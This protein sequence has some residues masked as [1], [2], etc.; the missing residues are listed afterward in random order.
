MILPRQLFKTADGAWCEEDDVRQAWAY[1]ATGMN[2]PDAEAEK[3]GLKAYL[4]A[5]DKAHAKEIKAAEKAE[6]KAVEQAEVEDKAV[7]GPMEVKAEEQTTGETEDK[8]EDEPGPGLHIPLE[9]RRTGGGRRG[10]A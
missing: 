5:Y 8:P 9:S 10:G 3:I 2:I 4:N 6:A 7:A 1:G